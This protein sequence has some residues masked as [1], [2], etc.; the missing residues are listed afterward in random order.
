MAIGRNFHLKENILLIGATFILVKVF[1]AGSI[2][3]GSAF[4]QSRSEVH[5][6]TKIQQRAQEWLQLSLEYQEELNKIKGVCSDR[7]ADLSTILKESIRCVSEYYK[8]IEKYLKARKMTW[9]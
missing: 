1:A 2:S 5:P 9:Y 3:S 7:N 8:R 4:S 6:L